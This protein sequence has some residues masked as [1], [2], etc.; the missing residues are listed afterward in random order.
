MG[1]QLGGQ[2]MEFK[3]RLGF[4]KRLILIHRDVGSIQSKDE[5]DTGVRHQDGRELNDIHF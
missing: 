5:G 2:G 4:Q 1:S 3:D